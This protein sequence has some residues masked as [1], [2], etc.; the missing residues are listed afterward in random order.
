[1]N[2]HNF[3][4]LTR[5]RRGEGHRETCVHIDWDGI[6]VEHLRILAKIAI[7]HNIQ[8]RIYNSTE[9][10][11]KEVHIVAKDC[12]HE[13]PAALVRFQPQPVKSLADTQLAKLLSTLSPEE[14]RNLLT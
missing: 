8:A 2:T 9:P 13:E 5:R 10:V 12:V 7:V 14:L 11:P 1:M 4:I 6:T 3:K